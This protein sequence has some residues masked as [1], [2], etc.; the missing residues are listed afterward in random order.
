MIPS[1]CGAFFSFEM[2][3]KAL[4]PSAREE[5]KPEGIYS[6]KKIKIFI[7]VSILPMI[8]FKWKRNLHDNVIF[9]ILF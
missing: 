6:P 8:T 4:T 7:N 2:L 3:D 9:K 1:F 5:N